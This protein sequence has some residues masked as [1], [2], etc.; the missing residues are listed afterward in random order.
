MTQLSSVSGAAKNESECGNISGAPGR[1][2]VQ[3]QMDARA[4]CESLLL[5]HPVQQAMLR[6]PT[7]VF[8]LKCP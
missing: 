8:G 2:A 1:A 3:C 4:P 7:K 6:S 5:H